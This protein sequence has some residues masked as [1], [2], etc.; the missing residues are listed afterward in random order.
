MLNWRDGWLRARSALLIVVFGF[1]GCGA[2]IIGLEL[3]GLDDCRAFSRF[4]PG[5]L[6]VGICERYGSIVA[7]S[8]LILIGAALIAF[9]FV[10]ARWF[11]EPPAPTPARRMTPRSRRVWTVIFAA[12]GLYMIVDGFLLLFGVQPCSDLKIGSFQY[13]ALGDGLAKLCEMFG[14]AVPA[15]FFIVFGAFFL[16]GLYKGVLDDK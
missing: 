14:P 3:A 6:G 10:G 13:R 9:L 7:A 8:P 11:R 5:R 2:L 1:A 4:Y 16:L 15:A 12:I